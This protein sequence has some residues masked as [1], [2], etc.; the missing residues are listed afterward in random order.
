MDFMIGQI[1]LTALDF[2]PTGTLACNGQAVSTTTYNALFGVLG[3]SYGGSGTTTFGVPNIA[4]VQTQSGA[5]LN[6][7]IVA[8]GAPWSSGMEAAL[9]E[10]RLLPASPPGNSTLAQSWSPC[11]GRGIEISRDEP[12][13]ALIG[14]MFGGDG[15]KT[16]ALPMLA[17]VVASNGPPLAYWIC[18]EGF[19]P[20][21][22]SGDSKTPTPGSN[23]FETY[24]G[25]V[26]QLPYV[27]ELTTGI[28]GLGLCLGQTLSIAPWTALFSLLGTRFGGN[29]TT[30]FLLPNR[31]T[32]GGSITYATVVNGYYPPRT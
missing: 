14:S 30:N 25:S 27:P 4:P 8:D 19:F 21:I 12:L 15:E 1:L 5:A 7:V 20:P 11:D 17:S 18:N 13:F 28:D 31:P 2:A 10:V 23:T 22:N 9:G 6:W 26:L 3:T 16:F 29:G 24:L 32:G